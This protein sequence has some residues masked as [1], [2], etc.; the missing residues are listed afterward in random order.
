M[1]TEIAV[2]WEVTPC[3]LVEFAD[4]S[5]DISVYIIKLY[6]GGGRAHSEHHIYK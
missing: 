4:L 3:S 1:L 5:E 2:G 6:D